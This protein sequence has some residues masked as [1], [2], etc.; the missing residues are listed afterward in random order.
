MKGRRRKK[1]MKNTTI[2]ITITD[3]RSPAYVL[4]KL[5]EHYDGG[6]VI[7]YALP[8]DA[9]YKIDERG[10]LLGVIRSDSTVFV[11]TG[12]QCKGE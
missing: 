2:K 4:H 6:Q 5:A 1:M 3:G 8:E 12:T 11:S 10:H 9:H 7:Q